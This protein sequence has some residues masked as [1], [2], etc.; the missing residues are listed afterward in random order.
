MDN[1]FAIL[2]AKGQRRI[3]DLR[4]DP[5]NEG[6]RNLTAQE[7]EDIV[8]VLFPPVTRLKD[9][10]NSL[11]ERQKNIISQQLKEQKVKDHPQI[12]Q[13]ISESLRLRSLKSII[14]AGTPYGLIVSD[15]KGASVMQATLNTK[16]TAGARQGASGGIKHQREIVMLSTRSNPYVMITFN[17]RRDFFNIMEEWRPL[18]VGITVQDLL[19]GDYRI[20]SSSDIP[21][22]YDNLKDLNPDIYLPSHTYRLAIPLSK[23]ILFN[24]RISLAEVA[25]ILM[26]TL[27]N[28]K[29]KGEF[30]IVHNSPLSE[31][32][33]IHLIPNNGKITV[34]ETVSKPDERKSLYIINKWRDV[35]FATTISG[36]P[37]V[38]SVVPVVRKVI[39]SVRRESNN[40]NGTSTLFIKKDHYRLFGI[41][42]RH[43]GKLVRTALGNLSIE[44]IDDM[45]LQVESPKFSPSTFITFRRAPGI[46][47]VSFNEERISSNQWRITG[48]NLYAIGDIFRQENVKMEEE[49]GAFIVTEPT[50]NVL[51]EVNA[52]LKYEAEQLIQEEE[53][54]RTERQ[55]TGKRIS[56]IQP[57]RRID[58]ASE[59]HQAEVQ[60][61]S[62]RQF[63][64]NE[65]IDIT[66]CYSNDTRE[67]NEM[68]GSD[69]AATFLTIEIDETWKNS[70]S[71]LQPTSVITS[72]AAMT[73]RGSLTP[74]SHSGVTSHN[75]G[76]LSKSTVW[77]AMHHLT[78]AGVNEETDQIQS[79]SAALMIGKKIKMGTG[80]VETQSTAQFL[81]KEEENDFGDVEAEVQ[82]YVING[83]RDIDEVRD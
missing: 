32:P 25:R 62:L 36:K 37:G 71:P 54:I 81:K 73:Y 44:Y 57:P 74:I 7:I 80:I 5:K 53:R 52:V 39:N 55:T 79:A 34:K 67:I 38:K 24:Y 46:P 14:P 20:E 23:Q 50:M 35:I 9:F 45:T 1:T 68:L 51:S 26:E 33:V 56:I 22:W 76:F 8:S 17:E 27:M 2:K 77:T 31:R 15:D 49:D 69:C 83:G 6:L 61:G 63:V 13:R 78:Q 11:L 75:I 18:V 28:K 70:G 42:S 40:K 72:V 4:P 19:L 29:T 21:S 65:G 12:V 16:R 59:Y 48:R 3:A 64:I 30:V 41:T 58:L 43:V 66:R 10:R 47:E 82:E 60:G